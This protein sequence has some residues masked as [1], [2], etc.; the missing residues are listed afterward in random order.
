VRYDQFNLPEF[1]LKLHSDTTSA[2]N[3]VTAYGPGFVEIN[4]IRFDHAIAFGP[5]GD[6]ARWAARDPSDIS[7]DLL[8]SAA[9][10]SLAQADPMAF[11]DSDDARPTVVGERPEVLLVGTGE[12]HIMLSRDI[13]DPLIRVGVGVECMSTAAAARTYNVLM[14]E[15]RL[16]IA[17]LIP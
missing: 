12:R 13:L 14:A 5:E 6:V 17:A 10:L 11:L 1:L 2:L 9:R 15:G 16:V 3:S 8:F 4:K 7:S